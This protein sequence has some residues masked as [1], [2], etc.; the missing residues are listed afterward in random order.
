[1]T[2]AIIFLITCVLFIAMILVKPSVEIKGHTV[3]IYY[4]PPLVGAFLLIFL[5]EISPSE[6]ARGLTADSEINPIKI[7]VLFLSMTLMSVFLDSVGFFRYLASYVLGHAKASQKSLFLWLYL[8]VSVLTIFTSNDIIVLT[9]T[10]FI[11]YFARNARI[12]AIPYLI[13]EFVAANT[14]SMTLI[15]GNP[16]NIYLMTGAGVSFIDYAVKMFVPTVF[17][18]VV[19]FVILRL[20]FNKKLQKTF[21]PSGEIAKIEDKTLTAIGVA[22][23][24]VCIGLMVVSSYISL[25]MWIISFGCFVSLFVFATVVLLF[26]KQGLGKIGETFKHAPYEIIPFVLSMFVLVLALDKVGLTE[27]IAD[28]LSNTD[29]IFGY[30]MVSFFSANLI[31][32]IPMS[33]LFSSVTEALSGTER[34]AALYASVAGSNL[35]AFLT[36]VGALAGIMWTAL[37]KK[38]G[39]K[40]SFARF[41]GYGVLLAIPSMLAVILG[42]KLVL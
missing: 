32:N 18:G 14:W 33:V 8:I 30:G 19:S 2:V 9:F 7:L 16:T 34:L 24:A 40:L 28:I 15:I 37:L 11:C 27:K 39:E 42:L 41:I 3:N 26:R 17:A 22:H 21:E 25:P 38:H 12:D 4:L 6:V 31:N 5:G 35:G 1:M 10:P 23:L 13:C 29:T 36:P 20:L